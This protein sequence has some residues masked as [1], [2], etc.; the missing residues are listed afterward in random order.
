MTFAYSTP[1][2]TD[3]LLSGML[4]Q[5]TGT[6]KFTQEFRLVSPDSDRFE[7]LL[8]AYYT[9][10]DSLI[11]Q[12]FIAVKPGTSDLVADIPVFADRR[13]DSTYEE[14]ALFG[15]ATWHL[16]DRFDL[17]F[18]ARWSDNDQDASQFVTIILP[19]FLF[20]PTPP[21]TI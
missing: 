17:S 7:W 10:E 13:L 20:D 19:G 18:G 12:N 2:T 8:G 16:T 3:R 1:G 11:D 4:F 21:R 9:D 15:N 14:L 5:N 6:D